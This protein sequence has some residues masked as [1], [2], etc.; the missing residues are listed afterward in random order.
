MSSIEKVCNF[1]GTSESAFR[2]GGITKAT[3]TRSLFNELAHVLDRKSLQLFR[4]KR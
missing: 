2:F 1:F 4:D 3:G